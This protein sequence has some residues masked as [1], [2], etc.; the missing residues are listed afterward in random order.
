[1]GILS[2]LESFGLGKLSEANVYDEDK[3]TDQNG[4]QAEEEK[5]KHV[6]SEDE[7]LF[8][9]SF[10]CP[11]CASSF[12]CKMVRTGKV[13]LQG[14]DLDLRPKYET[15][16][17]L[18]YDA[19]VCPKCGY[20]ALNRYY[21]YITAGQARM[22]KEQISINFKG[23]PAYG[24]A[25]TYED[26]INRHKLSL[27]STIVKRAHSSERAYNCL[28]LA[29]LY[30]G[31][32]ESLSKD[33]AEY[34]E[35]VAACKKEEKELIQN[36]YEGFVHAFSTEGFPMCGMDQHTMEYL[37]ASLAMQCGKYEDAVRMVSRIIVS[38]D[39]NER[40]KEKARVLKEK[41]VDAQKGI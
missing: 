10:S 17:V 1:M 24:S 22:V 29:W 14:A 23:L 7:L 16:D 38:R 13:K 37:I 11:I 40:T 34:Q 25:Y 32:A 15:V 18:K 36:A 26:A 20:A 4:Q 31:M 41:L 33:D 8:D 35:K 3:K 39:A 9:K 5:E 21:N 27:I 19:I 28:K 30:R 12:K 2:G 6:V